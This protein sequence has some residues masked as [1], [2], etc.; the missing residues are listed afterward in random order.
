M[1]CEEGLELAREYPV[2]TMN[3]SLD[4]SLYQVDTGPVAFPDLA[5]RYERPLE[6]LSLAFVAFNAPHFADFVIE[7]PTP[8]IEDGQELAQVYHFSN[9]FSLTA[10]NRLLAIADSDNAGSR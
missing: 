1:L 5:R 10:K 6:S 8:V 2:K 4:S 9:P 3:I 7:Q